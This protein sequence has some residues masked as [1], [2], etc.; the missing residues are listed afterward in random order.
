[1]RALKQKV[2]R[3]CGLSSAFLPKLFFQ[4]ISDR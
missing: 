1:M 3:G 2:G 4:Q